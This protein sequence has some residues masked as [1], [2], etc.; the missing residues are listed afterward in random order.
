[1]KKVGVFVDRWMSGGIESYLVSHFEHMD[2]SDLTIS[3]ITT[4]KFSSLY[5][6]R[7]AQMGIKIKEL[8]TEGQDSEL[9]RTYKSLKTFKVLVNEEDFDVLHLNIYNGVSLVYSK[10]ARKCGVQRVIAHSHNSAI[11]QVRLRRVKQVFHQLGKLRYASFASD[12]W[13]C[14]DL[15]GDWLFSHKQRKEIVYMANGIDT[16]KFQFSAKARTAFRKDYQLSENEYVLGSVG[17]LNNQKNQV[18]LITVAQ[19]LRER[20]IPFKLLIA[21]EGELKE[22]LEETIKRNQLEESVLLLG[23]ITDTPRFYSGIDVFLLPSLFEGNPIVGIEAQSS[24]VKCLFSDHIT[25]QA[26]MTRST[27]F[28][29]LDSTNEWIRGI[30]DYMLY[31]LYRQESQDTLSEHPF[32]ISQTSSQLKARLINEGHF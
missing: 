12:Y 9:T 13:A 28:L 31:P 10:I 25:R 14:S 16:K 30:E 22:Q 18:F 24:G 5:D 17:R 15:A 29:S 20:G 8:L 26:K 6:D 2:R 27:E 32:D 19:K 3:I 4:R 7:L 21:G 1:M 11:G 23:T